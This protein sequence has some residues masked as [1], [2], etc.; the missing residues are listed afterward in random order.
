MWQATKI[1]LSGFFKYV[2]YVSSGL[3]LHRHRRNCYDSCEP[4]DSCKKSNNLEDI[5]SLDLI[6]SWDQE[7]DSKNQEKTETTKQCKLPIFL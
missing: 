1:Y 5:D 4:S 3:F 7:S 2:N 6:D